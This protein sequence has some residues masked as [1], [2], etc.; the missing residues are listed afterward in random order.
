LSPIILEPF[1]I[2][3]NGKNR[4]KKAQEH[5]S[6]KPLCL[7]P[8]TKKQRSCK[9]QDEMIPESTSLMRKIEERTKPTKKE[10]SPKPQNQNKEA[11]KNPKETFMKARKR[12][13]R[14]S[15]SEQKID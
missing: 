3:P 4:K 6:F 11:Y 9:N 1:L 13:R 10:I 14:S 2:F 15:L 7:L 5:N 8:K 12:R